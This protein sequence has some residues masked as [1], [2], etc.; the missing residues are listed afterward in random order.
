M[1]NEITPYD[2]SQKLQVCA[3]VWFE[4][5]GR[6]VF[7]EGRAKLLRLVQE[8]K[9]I[10]LAAKKKGISFRRAWGIIK[11]M[12]EILGVTLVEKRRGG[13]GGGMAIVTP[14]ALELIESYEKI[15]TEFK[16]SMQ[17]K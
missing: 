10:N 13:V 16:R 9:S 4:L 11:E 14:K 15:N 1:Q 6:R 2:G 8:T 5:D 7:G 12:E 17:K 3:K